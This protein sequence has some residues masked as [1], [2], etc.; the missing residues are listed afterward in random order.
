M[1]TVTFI[2]QGRIIR[3][4]S[5]LKSMPALDKIYKSID[6][7]FI[8]TKKA[9]VAL[10]QKTSEMFYT[11]IQASNTR[12]GSTGQ[13]ADYVS[14]KKILYDTKNSFAIGIGNIEEL[15]VRACYWYFQNYGVSQKGMHI[16]GRGKW[17][18]GYFGEGAAPNSANAGTQ[19][20]TAKFNRQL[21][22]SFAMQAKSPIEP[23]HYIEKV[24]GWLSSVSYVHFSKI[25]GKRTIK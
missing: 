4:P 3:H 5:G 9:I 1:I 25:S 17:V 20:G 2:E 8:N 24:K 15:N 10:A 19:M 18:G 23:K 22:G 16:P 6:T 12:D 13:L 14:K 21:E 7:Y 11:T